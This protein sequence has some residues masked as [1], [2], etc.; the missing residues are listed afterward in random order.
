MCGSARPPGV[1]GVQQECRP[2][3]KVFHGTSDLTSV[4]A[5]GEDDDEVPVQDDHRVGRRVERLGEQASLP[6]PA[7]TR[8]VM[9]CW[10]EM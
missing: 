8:A 1:L 9:S 10:M 6:A 2:P 7:A 3:E 4:G 5:V